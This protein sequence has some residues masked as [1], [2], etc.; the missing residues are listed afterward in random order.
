MLATGDECS[1]ISI[2]SPAKWTAEAFTMVDG[3]EIKAQSYTFTRP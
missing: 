3:S 2:L 1:K